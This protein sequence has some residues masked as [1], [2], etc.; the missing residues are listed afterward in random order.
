MSSSINAST[1]SG[2]GV[3]TTA[4]A[5][6]ILQLQTGG[7]TAL[8]IDAS[9]NVTFANVPVNATAQSM[10]HLN[11]GNGVGSTN[12]AIGRYTT[13]ITNQG[14]DITY[15]DSATLGA[16]FTTNING[17]Y[18]IS[19]SESTTSVSCYFGVSLNSAQLT[20]GIQSITLASTLFIAV[21]VLNSI[22]NGSVTLYL[23][24]GSVV[25][26]HFTV[27]TTRLATNT[28]FIMTRIA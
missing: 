12:T 9:Q 6:G 22:S 16:S 14:S 10:V 20:T 23:P 4:D 27:G 5:S 17:V 8:T 28:V 24:S 7:T 3:I 25:R 19:M 26:P 21:D 13:V 15:T 18:S 1:A 2:G 11:A